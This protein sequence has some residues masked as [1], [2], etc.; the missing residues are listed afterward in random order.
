MNGYLCFLPP[1][2]ILIAL[3]V[4]VALNLTWHQVTTEQ[5][6]TSEM[7]SGGHIVIRPGLSRNSCSFHWKSDLASGVLVE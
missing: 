3:K 4:N 7:V 1:I 6:Q 5:L 2:L